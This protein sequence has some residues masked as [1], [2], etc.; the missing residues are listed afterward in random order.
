[1]FWF[2]CGC[3][4]FLPAGVNISLNSFILLELTRNHEDQAD[5]NQRCY[6]KISKEE[7]SSVN[8]VHNNNADSYIAIDDGVKHIKKFADVNGIENKSSAR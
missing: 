2:A 3:K 7:K 8:M 5:Y 6:Y 1:M 4:Y